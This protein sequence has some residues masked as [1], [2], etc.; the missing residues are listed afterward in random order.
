LFWIFP[1]ALESQLESWMLPFDPGLYGGL[2]PVDLAPLS[3]DFDDFLEPIGVF[4]ILE[5]Q[6]PVKVRLSKQE[7]T[8]K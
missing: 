3:K 2:F 5:R 4:V 6:E 7:V 8:R 1:I